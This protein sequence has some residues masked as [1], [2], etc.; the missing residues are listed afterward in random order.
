LGHTN[1]TAT[2]NTRHR[3]RKTKSRFRPCFSTILWSLSG[4]EADICGTSCK[5][6]SDTN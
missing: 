4:P 6:Q 2:E 3:R 1:S 5:N